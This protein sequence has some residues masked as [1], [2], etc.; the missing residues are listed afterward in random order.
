MILAAVI[1]MMSDG[2]DSGITHVLS[3]TCMRLEGHAGWT[4]APH[5][6]KGTLFVIT[7]KLKKNK[8]LQSSVA[9]I[10]NE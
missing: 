4:H 7:H 10:M 3:Y 2:K 8:L 9:E 5:L 6:P 1:C